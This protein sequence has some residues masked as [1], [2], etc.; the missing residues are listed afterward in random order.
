MLTSLQ[1]LYYTTSDIKLSKYGKC[2]VIIKEATELTKI[3]IDEDN[4]N[5]ILQD[6]ILFSKDMKTLY[7][8]SRWKSNTTY[9]IPN[10][11]ET[12]GNYAFRNCN[13]LI[14]IKFTKFN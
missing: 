7:F 11:V 8:Y 10:E 6:D 1:S 14:S 5:Y 13:N 9:T 2:D 4:P 12:I 3:Q